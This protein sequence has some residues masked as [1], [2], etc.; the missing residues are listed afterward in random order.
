MNMKFKYTLAL[1]LFA[2]SVVLSSCVTCANFDVYTNPD[3]NIPKNAK[4]AI[5]GI[6][7]VRGFYSKT[8]GMVY[9][10]LLESIVKAKRFQVISNP[11][12]SSKYS[13]Y[14]SNRQPSLSS[15]EKIREQAERLGVDYYV[16]G[17]IAKDV[18]D[19][20]VDYSEIEDKKD[21]THKKHK[22]HVSRRGVYSLSVSVKIVNTKTG[23]IENLK[24]YS[25]SNRNNTEATVNNLRDYTSA[26]PTINVPALISRSV[27]EIS[28][29]FFDDLS[30]RRINKY[31]CFEEIDDMPEI[32]QAMQRLNNDNAQAACDILLYASGRANISLTSKATAFYMIGS[33]YGAYFDWPKAIEYYRRAHDLMPGEAKFTNALDDAIRNKKAVDMN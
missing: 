8:S 4:I 19:E 9:E 27:D 20:S 1:T 31:L 30:P 14:N 12:I 24:N 3:I 33:I 7:D 6:S 23:V 29:Y 22:Y 21:T 32:K 18:Y 17:T 15:D 13:E 2:I 25:T 5:G 26:P 11:L 16:Y 10:I 28:N